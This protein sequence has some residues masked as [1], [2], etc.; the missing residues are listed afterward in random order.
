MSIDPD[1]LADVRR[2]MQEQGQVR[3]G[4]ADGKAREAG[5]RFVIAG[6]RADQIE[7]AVGVEVGD[8]VHVVA[9]PLLFGQREQFRDLVA[10]EVVHAIEREPAGH[11]AEDAHFDAIVRRGVGEHLVHELA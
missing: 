5:R 11:V 10:V 2:D 8:N 6:I 9:V 7:H 1:L 3:P 4:V